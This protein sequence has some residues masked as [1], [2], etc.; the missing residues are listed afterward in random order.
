MSVYCRTHVAQDCTEQQGWTS[1]QA[2]S[3][4]DLPFERV[5][6]FGMFGKLS[7]SSIKRV[8]QCEPTGVGGGKE[9]ICQQMLEVPEAGYPPHQ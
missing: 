2:A 7:A 5:C 1:F 8:L 4:L 6:C 9:T 3:S